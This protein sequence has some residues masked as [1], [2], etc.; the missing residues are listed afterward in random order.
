M[1]KMALFGG[2]TFH[3][4]QEGAAG[5]TIVGC[6]TVVQASTT[7]R[8][9]GRWVGWTEGGMGGVDR[10]RDGQGRDSFFYVIIQNFCKQ[11]THTHTNNTHTTHTHNTQ[12]AHN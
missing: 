2:R 8:A 5:E 12:H 11:H 7:G 9:R 4:R 3:A 6:G 1:E 10:G